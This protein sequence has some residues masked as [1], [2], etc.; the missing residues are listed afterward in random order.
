M[1]N[2][3]DIAEEL[4]LFHSEA[5]G[6]GM[7]FWHPRGWR[8]FRTVK[9]H[10]RAAY[11]AESFQEV[12]TPQ[13]LKR[14]LWETSGHWEK[15]ADDMFVGAG[16]GE[17]PEYALKPMSC[18]AHILLYKRGVRSYKSLP[19]RLFEF[20][21]VH[22]NE[23]SGALN[24]LMR[25][26]QF[27]QDDAHV[28][29]RWDQVS[30]EIQAFLRR[31][32]RVYADYGY[33]RPQVFISTRPQRDYFGA[34]EDWERAEL[35]L[36]EACAAASAEFVRQEGEGAFY[37]PKIE[38]ALKDGQGRQWQM[39]TIQLDFNMPERF[40][41]HYIDAAGER[42]R[43]VILHQAVYGSIERWIG[44]LLETYQAALPAWVHPQ[45]V[46]LASVGQDAVAYCESVGEL[47]RRHGVPVEMDLAND[48]L[49]KKMKVLRRYKTP[50]VLIA[51][52][53]EMANDSIVVRRR[54]GEQALASRDELVAIVR[55]A[56]SVADCGDV[57]VSEST[58]EAAYAE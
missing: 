27:T 31:A 1:K 15:Y 33:G 19:L 21:L 41:L 10:I 55:E 11:E 12:A 38:L 3:R 37:G 20:G 4:D 44:V 45:P 9:N 47:L 26:R 14:E 43:P 49:A 23:R 40:D 34:P 16:F 13:F 29:C 22:R 53:Q 6:P 58:I 54:G 7:A 17:E 52:A 57:S 24:G 48:S 2:H 50:L 36:A 8:M 51:G 28:F 46:V 18:P 32:E 30:Q 39:G 25:L 35:M 56:L 42:R 5:Q